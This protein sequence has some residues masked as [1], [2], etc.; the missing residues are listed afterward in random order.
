MKKNR[1]FTLVELLITVAIGAILLLWVSDRFIYNTVNAG[2][3]YNKQVDL[4][5]GVKFTLD[6]I[7]NTLKNST[8]IHLVGKE[9][10]EPKMDLKKLDNRFNYIGLYEKD[11]TKTLAN[12]IYNPKKEE[13]EVFPIMASDKKDSLKKNDIVYDIKFYEDLKNEERNLPL[14]G[15]NTDKLSQE[16][17]NR[18]L[19]L[20]V[21][22]KSNTKFLD[23]DAEG[24]KVSTH[25]FALTENI[26]LPNT[27]QI[28]ISKFLEG[29]IDDITAIAYDNG[30]IKEENFKEND[31]KFAFVFIIDDSWSMCQ[32]LKSIKPDLL[33][34]SDNFM[35]INK[36]QFGVGRMWGNGFSMYGRGEIPQNRKNLITEEELTKDETY[37]PRK[38]ILKDVAIDNLFKPLSNMAKDGVEVEAYFV[39]FDHSV[40][41]YDKMSSTGKYIFNLRD[42]KENSGYGPYTLGVEEYKDEFGHDRG[43]KAAINYF[44]NKDGCNVGLYTEDYPNKYNNDRGTNTGLA[45]LQGLEILNQLKEEGIENRFL[46]LLTDGNPQA[47][48]SIA[49][50]TYRRSLDYS[51]YIQSIDNYNQIRTISYYGYRPYYI[52]NRATYDYYLS[53]KN[54]KFRSYYDRNSGW[55]PIGVENITL[56]SDLNNPDGTKID[57]GLD[58]IDLVTDPKNGNNN[59]AFTT[60]YLIGFSGV[61]QDKEKLG[62]KEIPGEKSIKSCL[63]R[64]GND[65]KAYDASSTQ[66]LVDSINQI[67]GDM[68]SKVN[69]FEGPRKMGQSGE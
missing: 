56:T 59:G 46:I 36:N 3:T 66:E 68:T 15:K 7:S 12:I 24:E 42:I 47:F 43:Y 28:M 38:L 45:L 13:F 50:R 16:L 26:R 2:N 20:T 58:Y 31:G 5:T 30:Q 33:D 64:G 17:K 32:N 61:N 65:V 11:G 4:Q 34:D 1:A 63:E 10:Y 8:Q 69:V 35:R 55:S 52:Y 22:G 21:N 49:A 60:A 6:N 48:T 54:T 23:E 18:I 57:Y 39:P 29:S 27:N 19:T 62:L 40:K 53:N 9:V 41:R 51:L 44:I 14:D 67:V 37:K 25:E